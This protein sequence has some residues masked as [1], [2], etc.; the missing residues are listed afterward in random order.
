MFLLLCIAFSVVACGGNN[1]DNGH[2]HT[3]GSEWAHDGEYH[4][5]AATCEHTDEVSDRAKH[6]FGEIV[7]DE[8]ATPTK[9]G[10]G[11]KSCSVCDITI[12][13]IE[14]GFN[15][16][17]SSDVTL[18]F[19]VRGGEKIAPLTVK[20]GTTIDLKKYSVNRTSGED[21]AF[22]GWM[23]GG[24]IV[25]SFVI[26]AD[27]V[28]HAVYSC[29]D[30]FEKTVK[31]GKYPQSV[32]TDQTVIDALDKLDIADKNAN[33]YYEYQGNEYAKEICSFDS[34]KLP[35]ERGKAYYFKVEPIIWEYKNGRY[36]TLRVID[37]VDNTGL[38]EYL[39]GDFYDS[40]TDEEK[41]FVADTKMSQYTDTTYKFYLW[42]VEQYAQS[43]GDESDRKQSLTDYALFRD[44]NEKWKDEDD[45]FTT[46]IWLS[47]T[48]GEYA[49]YYTFDTEDGTLKWNYEAGYTGKCGLLPCF[50]FDFKGIEKKTSDKVIRVTF[51]SNGGSELPSVAL[52][53]GEN[54]KIAV[55]YV[56][57]KAGFD[58]I[59]WSIYKDGDNNH[60]VYEENEYF[61]SDEDV[62]L[63]ARWKT[64]APKVY[65]IEYELNG[66]GF[67]S[68]DNIEK[69]YSSANVVTFKKPKK[70]STIS[71][72][73]VFDG[74]YLEEDFK[75]KVTS[76][77]DMTGS[78][79]VYAKWIEK[80]IY[81]DI[82]YDTNGG[83]ITDAEYPT[84]VLRA[85]G[86]ITLPTP[87]K[88]GYV[89]IGW[90]T[91]WQ[92]D[93]ITS[94]DKNRTG[95]VSLKAW[96]TP[97][98]G[99]TWNLDGGTLENEAELPTVVYADCPSI[100]VTE[101]VP[102]KEGYKFLYWS[103]DWT[104]VNGSRK[105]GIGYNTTLSFK[106]GSHLPSGTGTI[107]AVFAKTYFLTVDSMGGYFDD[108]AG[109]TVIEII[110]Y[111]DTV[112][113]KN[114]V[115]DGVTLLG[116]SM[117]PD[118]SS[119]ATYSDLY[120]THKY[121]TINGDETT[122]NPYSLF[123]NDTDVLKTDKIYA[124]WNKVRISFSTNVDGLSKEA[125]YVNY[126]EYFDLND[127]TYALDNVAGKK[128][129][130]WYI[131]KEFTSKCDAHDR[132][133]VDTTVYAKWVDAYTVTI[134]Y[135]NGAADYQLK[136]LPGDSLGQIPLPAM[137]ENEYFEGVFSDSE[138]SHSIDTDAWIPTGD[139]TI[140]VSITSLLT[141]TVD[142]S[143]NKPNEKYYLKSG[144]KLPA[145]TVKEESGRFF[146]RWEIKNGNTW[147]VFDPENDCIYATT[148]VKAVFKWK[149]TGGDYY[150]FKISID[151]PAFS[152]T[153]SD[154]SSSSARF[155][156]SDIGIVDTTKT[157]ITAGSAKG[158]FNER[159]LSEMGCK[160]EFDKSGYAHRVTSG[161]YTFLVFGTNGSKVQTLPQKGS[162]V[163]VLV[164]CDENP[165]A[166]LTAKVNYS[167]MTSSRSCEIE[168]TV[169][170]ESFLLN[171]NPCS[172]TQNVSVNNPVLTVEKKS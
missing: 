157:N 6:Q 98:Y 90:K 79:K 169:N 49:D 93:L 25:D 156:F 139:T 95:T 42:N 52:I 165:G 40:L 99:I 3:F 23:V 120:G 55:D 13:N 127:P 43:Y 63:Y 153:Y 118:C 137:Q 27:T 89:F 135:S 12:W 112:I 5:H 68:S 88:N 124:I 62:T 86:S 16:D 129:D 57:Q 45:R 4:W 72:N 103:V 146:Y 50:N 110:K 70:D 160:L 109:S 83:T 116:W 38:L 11:H 161:K 31:F 96:Y 145:L 56:P 126:N 66:G 142:Y 10:F 100:D 105:F 26:K 151:S 8:A 140:Y 106:D 168:M 60:D 134:K 44:T 159:V 164:K 75:T 132:F 59:G 155:S 21:I 97:A 22:K 35:F 141:V 41:M 36:T 104:S 148:T 144:E 131:D 115:K 64:E 65:E 17:T 30:Y 114:P 128:F 77:E 33:G 39:N 107:K 130:G 53:A 7:V 20:A 122:F 84:R 29:D 24:E 102:E 37:F 154:S 125:I 51:D 69:Q 73:Y 85:E 47:N 1:S 119:E 74:W 34:G 111:D 19:D 81:F 92:N 149:L 54:Y 163:Y 143:D 58:F 172:E 78:I 117:Y 171:L 158:I 9:N 123:E 166:N 136:V 108:N 87:Q 18:L 113:F 80:G 28:V 15:Y 14:V 147:S 133:C 76:T 46:R 67:D 71:Y 162:T 150:G 101:F 61:K 48:V 82:N 32:V 152:Y 138:Y 2:T 167:G 91:D 94:I 170:G 121:F